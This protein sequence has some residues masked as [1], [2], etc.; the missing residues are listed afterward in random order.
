MLDRVVAGEI[1]H[2]AAGLAHQQGA[3]G[4][5]PGLDAD[6]EVGVQAPGRDPGEVEA[7]G[8]GAAEVLDLAEDRL[9]DPRVGLQFSALAER[10]GRRDHRAL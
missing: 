4:D 8:A 5:V 9:E 6:L 2:H 1:Q 7:G 3:G 10:K